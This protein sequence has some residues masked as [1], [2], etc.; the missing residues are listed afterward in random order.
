MAERASPFLKWAGGKNQLLPAILPRFPDR[1]RIYYEPFV[2][3]GAVFF[4]LASE[5]RI[6]EAVLGDMNR[7][8]IET[9][10]VVRDDVETL[11][12]A[13]AELAPHAT[14][15]ERYYE[16]RA[17]DPC[18]LEPVGRAARFIFLNKTCFNGLY[19]VNRSGRFNVPFG[20]YKRP[21]VL[22]EAALHRASRALTRA[23]LVVEDFETT[24]AAV[25]PGD[26]VYFDPPYAPA[27]ETACFTSYHRSPFGPLEHERLRR[28]YCACWQQGAV[29]VLSNSDTPFTQDLYR[30]LEFETVFAQ[31]AINR[32][33]NRRGHVSEML[34]HGIRAR[35]SRLPTVPSA[36]ELRSRARKKAV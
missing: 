34:V 20:R 11:V 8:L 28:V 6:G 3:G 18:S 24:V 19:R 15:S 26:A 23:D 35:S 12:E 9:Y 17:V 31:R 27:S 10:R 2:G 22:D 33:P 21:R 13:L 30:G 16:V 14:S 32:D 7:D 36:E 29:A 25:G 4:A 5:G 1:I